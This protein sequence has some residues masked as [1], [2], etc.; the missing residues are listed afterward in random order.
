M[1]PRAISVLSLASIATLTGL[2]LAA[3]VPPPLPLAGALLVLAQGFVVRLGWLRE[4]TLR[5][6]EARFRQISSA[7]SDYVFTSRVNARGELDH[8]TLN[9]A[10]E[11]ITGYTPEAYLAAGGWRANLHPD[12]LEQ[13]ARDLAALRANQPVKTEVRIIRKDGTMRWVRVLASPVWDAE[14]GRLVGINGGVRDITDEKQAVEALYSLNDSLQNELA[15]RLRLEAELQ[16]YNQHLE[17]LVDERTTELRRAKEQLELI[18][19]NTTDALAF[20][21]ARGDILITNPAF[22]T[23]FDERA[24]QAIEYILWS[25][26]D[27]D[28]T[29]RMGEALLRV[30]YDGEPQRVQ[31]RVISGA[32]GDRDLELALIPMEVADEPARNGVLLSGRDITHIK[33]IE[34]FKAR[35]IA[36]ALHDLATPITGLSMRLSLL[37]RSP[38]RLNE[39]LRTL[40][41]Q[42]E[43]LRQLLEDLRTLSRIDRGQNEL[44]K[45]VGPLNPL[46]QRVYDTYEPVALDKGQTFA[47]RLAEA[48]PDLPLDQR[49]IERVLVNLVSNA[50]NYT[51]P[52]RGIEISTG[53]DGDTLW[54]AVADE[55]MGISADDLPRI[56]DRFYRTREAQRLQTGGTGLGLA[57]CKEIAELHGGALRVVSA[58]GEGSTFTLLLPVSG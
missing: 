18:L 8:I 52:G 38:E 1:T 48:L 5:A 50:I 14:A 37:R 20:A 24:P 10:F 22:A 12:D 21:D 33:E 43:H 58:P 19:I 40:E 46:V 16:R 31:T 2:I 41:N 29:A 11:A 4:V 28:Q 34:R 6:S 35:F 55:G 36:D 15:E 54:V 49:Q 45:T 44:E 51:E 30:M 25:L 13:D 23:A 27:A 32:Q 26:D 7:T 56:F 53:R 47:L 3:L 57:I 17:A 39:H 9:G 42:V